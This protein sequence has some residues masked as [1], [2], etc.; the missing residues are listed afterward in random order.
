MSKDLLTLNSSKAKKFFLSPKVYSSLELPDYFNFY[1][2]VSKI[3]KKFS[4]TLLEVEI[5]NA[6]KYE[7]I[8]HVLYGNKDGKYAW[9]KYEIINP[10]LYIS[11]VNLITTRSNWS[12]IRNRFKSFQ[13]D[14]HIESGGLPVLAS[15]RSQ[16]ESQIM[17]WVGAIEK[18][19]LALS[20]EYRFLFQTDI[21]DCYGSI[22]THTLPW[23]IHTKA[24]AKQKRSYGDLFGN[25]IDHHMQAMSSGQTNGIPQGSVLMDF[26]AEIVLGYADETLSTRL[27]TL[28]KGRDYRI[29][30]YRDDYRIFVNDISDGEIIMKSLSE[31]LIELGLRLHSHKTF[32]SNDVISG[33]IKRDKLEAIFLS[34]VPKSLSKKE[35]LRQLLIV[36]Q[37]GKKFPNTG[38]LKTRLSEIIRAAKLNNFKGQEDVL[39]GVLLDIAFDSPNTFHLIAALISDCVANRPKKE[40]EVYIA[41]V[42]KKICMLPNIGLLEA[43]TQRITQGLKIYPRWNEKLCKLASKKV[44]IFETDWITDQVI[45]NIIDNTDYLDKKVFSKV[46]PRISKKEVLIF[47]TQYSY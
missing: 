24:I 33:S 15:K 29:L 31:A 28:L 20:L 19:S 47:S 26:M 16:R 46:K 9:R 37:I 30:R 38:T 7:T 3:A 10:L 41:K 17:Q 36:Q 43:W 42:Q 5:K 39:M 11:L 40:Q 22:Y 6:K 44:Q 18:K 32:Q 2:A 1:K 13:S 45:K 23:A 4:S 21:T 35:L 14:S 8:N 25:Q 27:K 12:L 34:S